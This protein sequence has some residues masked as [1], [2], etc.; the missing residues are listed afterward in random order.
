MHVILRLAPRRYISEITTEQA[1][2]VFRARS[3]EI[4]GNVDYDKLFKVP[5]AKVVNPTL[6]TCSPSKVSQTHS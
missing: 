6:A 4:G 2:E 1:L 3:R 5:K